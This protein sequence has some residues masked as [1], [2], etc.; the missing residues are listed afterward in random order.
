MK[1]KNIT[2]PRRTVNNTQKTIT[3]TKSVRKRPGEVPTEN[4][5][6]PDLQ[7]AVEF[8]ETML[9]TATLLGNRLH[10]LHGD[11]STRVIQESLKLAELNFDAFRARIQGAAQREA[12]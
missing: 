1:S 2:Q 5:T 10:E 6:S 3:G 8:C 12:L 11:N 9:R 7:T 4:P